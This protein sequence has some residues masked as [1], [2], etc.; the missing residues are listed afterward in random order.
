MFKRISLLLC[1][2]IMAALVLTAC[3]GSKKQDLTDSKYVGT[4]ECS[5]LSL[6]DEKEDLDETYTLILNGDGSGEFIG[7]GESSKFNWALT[8][9]GFKTSGDVKLTFKD[10]GNNIK[11]SFLGVDLVFV[12]Q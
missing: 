10:D 6:M 8:S 7:E 1:V 12:K 2:M 5:S 3:G 4:W 11:T 9:D